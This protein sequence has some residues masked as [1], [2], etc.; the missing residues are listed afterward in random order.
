MDGSTP[1]VSVSA[2][3]QIEGLCA[4]VF[5]PMDRDGG[6]DCSQ[7][8]PVVELLLE[9]K[10]DGLYVCGSTGEGVSLTSD[11]RRAVAAAYIEAVGGRAPVIVHGEGRCTE[12]RALQRALA[13]AGRVQGRF[14]ILHLA[15]PYGR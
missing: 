15:R 12:A 2:K 8:G 9:S 6:V 3:H 14:Q 13:R 1:E 4:A 7:I 11:E 10:V 5:T